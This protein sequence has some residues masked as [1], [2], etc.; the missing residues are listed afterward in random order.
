M[1]QK[2]AG[3]R[4]EPPRSETI[5]NGVMAA[6]TA[7]AAPPLRPAGG[8]GEV[9]GVRGPPENCVG[10]LIV[11][12]KRRDVAVRDDHRAGGVQARGNGGVGVGEAI[13]MLSAERGAQTGNVDAVLERERHT[14]QRTGERAAREGGIGGLGLAVGRFDIERHQRIQRGV[15]L[16]DA[17]A[18]K[19]SSASTADSSRWAILRASSL[20]GSAHTAF[21]VL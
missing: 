16:L 9:P 19:L 1:P 2:C 13:E 5:S 15:A 11:G 21:M 8:A 17:S 10:A 6:A 14:V 3:K 20:A 12:K 7:A 18:G 4:M